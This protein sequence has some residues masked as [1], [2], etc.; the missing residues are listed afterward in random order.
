MNKEQSVSVLHSNDG[1]YSEY[2]YCV[3]YYMQM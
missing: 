3:N 1:S 2:V